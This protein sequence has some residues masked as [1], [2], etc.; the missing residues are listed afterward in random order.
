MVRRKSLVKPMVCSS[1]GFLLLLLLLLLLFWDF[2]VVCGLLMSARGIGQAQRI[3]TYP[4]LSWGRPKGLSFSCP[5]SN[6]RAP[7]TGTC[8]P[9]WAQSLA[10]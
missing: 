5:P 10:T 7:K 8:R 4:V 6:G 1:L 2:K 9:R 3:C